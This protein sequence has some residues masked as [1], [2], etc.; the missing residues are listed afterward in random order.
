MSRP[1]N[2]PVMNMLQIRTKLGHLMR[3]IDFLKVDIEGAEWGLFKTLLDSCNPTQPLFVHLNI[4]L[5]GYEGLILDLSEARMNEHF[6]YGLERC[7]Y[8]IVS[9]EP[10]TW[11]C[12]GYKCIEYTFIHS[13]LAVLE[14]SIAYGCG[15]SWDGSIS[16]S[17]DSEKIGTVMAANLSRMKSRDITGRGL[18]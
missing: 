7:G 10:N 14:H 15:T 2:A 4:E 17:P 8:Y 11:G 6:F 5:H 9:K 13:S 3:P 1:T 12:E 18:R 16:G